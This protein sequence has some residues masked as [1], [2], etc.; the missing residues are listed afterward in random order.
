MEEMPTGQEELTRERRERL[1]EVSHFLDVDI[2]MEI[3]MLYQ[4]EILS[5]LETKIHSYFYR[6]RIVC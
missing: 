4:L 3:Q 2:K 6:Q 5:T 1:K